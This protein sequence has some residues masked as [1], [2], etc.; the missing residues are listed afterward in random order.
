M[1]ETTVLLPPASLTVFSADA[2]TRAAIEALSQDWRFARVHVVAQE[3]DVETAISYYEE[4]SSPELLIVQT[5]TIDES[6]TGRLG[7]LAGNC[8]E[9]TDAIVI[10]PVNDVQL[11]RQLIDMGVSDYI[12]KPV[13]TDVFAEVVAKALIAKIG[14][15]K[16]KLI[17]TMGSKGGTGVSTLAQGLALGLSDIAGQ[18]TLLMD[19]AG[20][21]SSNAVALGHEPSTTLTEAAKVV[22]RGDD[23]GLQRMILNV[24]DKLGILASG[25]DPMLDPA[26][27]AEGM[28]QILTR[29]MASYPVV[30]A[31]AS[32]STSEVKR[33]LV[34][35]AQQILLIITPGLFSLRQSRTLLQEI[36]QVRGGGDA[37]GPQSD[38]ANDAVKLI[39]NFQGIL[40]GTELGEKEISEMLEHEISAK[41]PFDSKLFGGFK[42]A[43]L[44]MTED[45]GGRALI[46]SLLPLLNIEVP[47]GAKTEVAAATATTS[48][49]DLI[50]KLTG[51][52]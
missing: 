3:G 45:K 18:K 10:G 26:I 48:L 21:W 39:L 15:Q 1:S 23:D 9:G 8:S 36:N 50:G 6:F 41:I 25:G 4:Y 35:Q 20:G 2:S 24:N 17:V 42:G 40:G 33:T 46:E 11:Y 12:V 30:L 52:G 38:Q 14:I 32:G 27:D 43:G 22:A 44:K 13:E 37:T 51:K 5:E 49:G 47:K 19:A 16:S 31:D 7:A 29:L 28:E 34:M